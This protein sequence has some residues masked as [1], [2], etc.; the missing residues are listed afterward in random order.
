MDRVE[1]EITKRNEARKRHKM[2][3]EAAHEFASLGEYR[4]ALLH[5]YKNAERE[6][7]KKNKK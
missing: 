5:S 1:Q 2:A 6:N 3:E 7:E 4:D